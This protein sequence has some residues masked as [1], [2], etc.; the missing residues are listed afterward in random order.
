MDSDPVKTWVILVPT[1]RPPHFPGKFKFF[2]TRY[3][4]LWDAKVMAVTGGMTILKPGEGRWMSLHGELFEERVIPVEV[5]CTRAQIEQIMDITAVHYGQLA[6]YAR[7]VS[8]E[9]LL[10]HYEQPSVKKN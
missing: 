8:D 4:K 1:A 7:K 2:S 5:S 10:K 9:V 3:H 6:V